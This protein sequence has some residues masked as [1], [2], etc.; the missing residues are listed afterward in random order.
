MGLLQRARRRRLGRHR[1]PRGVRRRRPGDHRGL[2]DAGGDRRVGC[3]D[4]RL[5]G[6]PPVDLR[7]GAGP[8]LRI[9]RTRQ[10]GADAGRLRRAARRV[11][12]HR[13]RRRHRHHV[14]PHPCGPRRRRVRG[15][16]RQGVD[17]EGAVLRDVP[18]AGAHDAARGVR[19]ADRRHDAADGRP[20]EA[21]G[22]HHPDPQ[23][24]PQRRRV[25][26]GALRRSARAGQPPRRRGGAGVPVPASTG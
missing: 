3:G 1:H 7:D 6:D 14:D 4:E 8:P 17:H 9:A 10:G 24:R 26:R 21:R 11:R 16:R 13:A 25:V 22:R 5:L 2:G 15:A 12:R 19:Q 23:A 18:A 20:A